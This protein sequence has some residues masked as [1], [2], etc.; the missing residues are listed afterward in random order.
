MKNIRFIK[1]IAALTAF[2]SLAVLPVSCSQ[3]DFDIPQKGVLELEAFYTTADDADVLSALASIY[4]NVYTG[5]RGP[6]WYVAINALSDDCF[7]GSAF[8]DNDVWQ[9]FS[10][11]NIV[12]TN[13]TVK[14]LYQNYYK[15]IY[16]C[17]LLIEKVSPDTDIKKR[18]TAE[19]K[20]IRAFCHFDLIRLWGN[21]VMVDKVISSGESNNMPNTPADQTY[22]FIEQD[23]NDAIALLPSKQGISGQAAIGG[24]LTAEA[25]R[26]LLGKVQ[27]WQ[28][29]YAEAAATLKQIINSNL[30]DLVAMDALHR[31]AADFGAEYLWE[32]NAADN[33]T[34]YNDQGDM[35]IAF[36]GWR[37]DNVDSEGAGLVPATWGFGAVTAGFA[38]FLLAHDGGKSPRW[39]AWVAD[40]EDILDMGSTGVW[41]PPVQSNQ[42]YFRLTRQARMED[43]YTTSFTWSM[44]A[45]SKANEVWIRYAEVLLLYAEA[46]LNTG[47]DADGSGLAALN[48]I[49]LRA[50]LP[51]LASYDLPALKNEKR[52][53]MFFEGERY[54]D[55]VRWGDAATIL[56]DKGKKWY[57]F[58]GYQEGTTTWN[59][60]TMDGPGSGWSDKYKCLPFPLDE[61]TANPALVQN[62][63]W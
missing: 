15:L 48:K 4:K 35:R 63:G 31:L 6:D 45:R 9:Q 50:G 2:L 29:N 27:L 11:Y 53:E 20:A 7:A 49:R 26:A 14:S 61:L 1:A 36:L 42:G 38:E 23:L 3:D 16:W 12:T 52:A 37:S 13:T 62:T 22:A 44:L 59:I 8:T 17:N 32:F 30:Y 55:L 51:A 18:V 33:A 10:N 40:Y 5:V 56:R 58:Y 28:G 47:N 54:F 43:L 21:P 39:K 57:S 24:R 34:N 46:Q 41:A 25:A 19:A 60:Q